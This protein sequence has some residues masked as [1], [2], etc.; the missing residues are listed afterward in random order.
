MLDVEL[1][2]KMQLGKL[3]IVFVLLLKRLEEGLK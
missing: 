3:Y 2:K 1:G